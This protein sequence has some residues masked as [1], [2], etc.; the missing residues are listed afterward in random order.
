MIL[1]TI[2]I[3]ASCDIL[4]DY[5]SSILAFLELVLLIDSTKTILY[6]LGLDLDHI[7]DI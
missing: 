5:R 2:N 3:L 4:L 6:P 7:P 1:V